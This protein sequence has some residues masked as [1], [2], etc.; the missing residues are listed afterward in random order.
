MPSLIV[1]RHAKAVAG[2]ELADIDRPLNDRGRRDA[3]ATGKWLRD[4]KLL[5][6]AVLCSPA[7]RTRQTLDGLALPSGTAS[8]S[9]ESR[10]YG[11]DPDALLDLIHRT[12][13]DVGR[14]LVIGHNPSVHQLAYDL[15]GGPPELDRFPTCALALIELPGSWA[16]ARPGIGELITYRTPKKG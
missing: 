15:T 5:P 13:D 11:N 10:I 8:V 7:V 16:D 3:V 9:Y 4:E 12:G 2:L 14:L 1:L 6:D